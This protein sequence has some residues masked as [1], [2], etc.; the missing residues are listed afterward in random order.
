[1]LGSPSEDGRNGRAGPVRRVIRPIV[2]ARSAGVGRRRRFAGG[3]IHPGPRSARYDPVD[4]RKEMT[5][6]Q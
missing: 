4:F 2:P 5:P 3:Q 1:M 6:W